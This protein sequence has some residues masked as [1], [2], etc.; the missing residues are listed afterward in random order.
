MK[1][2]IAAA[3]V[4]LFAAQA[5]LAATDPVEQTLRDWGFKAE[6]LE[7]TRFIR[8]THAEPADATERALIEAG[9][10]SPR[11]ETVTPVRIVRESHPEISD[12]VEQTLVKWGF[13]AAP[14]N[15]RSEAA[16]DPVEVASR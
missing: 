8:T 1:L 10:A 5:S 2:K 11:V 15:F 14:M 9:F 6:P 3:A 7:D 4:A 13:K 12:P 16:G